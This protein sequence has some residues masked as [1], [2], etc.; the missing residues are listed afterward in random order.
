MGAMEN[1]VL[2]KQP[3]ADKDFHLSVET[4]FKEKKIL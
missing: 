4:S 2:V 1:V 3:K